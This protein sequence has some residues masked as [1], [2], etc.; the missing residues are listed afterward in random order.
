MTYARKHKY[1]KHRNVFRYNESAE[2][3]IR[4]KMH[5]PKLANVVQIRTLYQKDD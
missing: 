5:S 1:Y 4:I 2:N 3:S